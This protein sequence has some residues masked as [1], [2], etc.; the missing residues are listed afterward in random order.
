MRAPYGHQQCDFL[1]LASGVTRARSRNCS[2]IYA[3]AKEFS[4][5]F[6]RS[7][8]PGDRSEAHPLQLVRFESG[9]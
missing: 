7:F 8:F 2:D 1:V 3:L 6:L 4:T 5:V 9:G